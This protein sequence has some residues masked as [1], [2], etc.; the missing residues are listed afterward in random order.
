[1]L[2]KLCKQCSTHF[3]KIN[4]AYF[5][6]TSC[7]RIL[8]S[9]RVTFVLTCWLTEKNIYNI[10]SSKLLIGSLNLQNNY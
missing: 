3:G 8:I 7:V 9:C 5:Y 1:M 10:V 2:F 6:H 4:L